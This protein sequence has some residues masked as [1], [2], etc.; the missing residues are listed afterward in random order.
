MDLKRWKFRYKMPPPTLVVFYQG[1]PIAELEQAHTMPGYLFRY[2]PAFRMLQLSPFPGLPLGT[3]DR[4]FYDLPTY[5]EER[6]PDMKRP[7]ISELV[8]LHKVPTD[9][10]LHLLA[11]LGSQTITDPFEFRLKN[12]A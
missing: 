12:A 11:L 8:R 1:H 4:H 2:L 5:F 6:L 9:S 3:D 10:K 7:E